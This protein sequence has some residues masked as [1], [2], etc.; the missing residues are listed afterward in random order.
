MVTDTLKQALNSL[1][2]PVYRVAYNPK[3]ED[4][5]KP[6]PET[7]FTLQNIF[8]QPSGYADDDSTVTLH[9]LGVDIYTKSDFTELVS[10]TITVLKQAGFTISSIDTE[11]YEYDTGYYHVPIT[12]K[13]MEE[14]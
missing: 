5:N 10:N 8:S 4:I 7:F 6:I 13:I 2:K 12:I 14:C 11:I 3:E 9:T 1:N